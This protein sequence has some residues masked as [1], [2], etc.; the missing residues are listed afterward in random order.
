MVFAVEKINCLGRILVCGCKVTAERKTS[1][2]SAFDCTEGGDLFQAFRKSLF[3][4]KI[5]FDET[6]E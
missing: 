6:G 5:L 3:S 4:W 2:A 1:A